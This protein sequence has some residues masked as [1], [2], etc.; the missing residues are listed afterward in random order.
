MTKRNENISL[1]RKGRTLIVG[2]DIAKDIQLAGMLDSVTSI[3]VGTALKFKY[4]L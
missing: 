4:N 1:I 3:E 2:I